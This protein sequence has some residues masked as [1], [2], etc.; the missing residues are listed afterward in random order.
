MGEIKEELP[1][2]S[3]FSKSIYLQFDTLFHSI[4]YSQNVNKNPKSFTE[5]KT[6]T[7]TDNSFRL[8]INSVI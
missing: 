7:R 3:T 1:V 5:T 2:K 8:S 4:F 6:E